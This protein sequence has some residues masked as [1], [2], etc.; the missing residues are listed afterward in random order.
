MR[1]TVISTDRR[2]LT[3]VA[4]TMR[5]AQEEIFGP[6]CRSSKSRAF[7]EAIEVLNGTPYGLSSSIYTQDVEP[8]LSAP[9]GTSKPAS[10]TS[11]ARP[12]APRSTCPSAA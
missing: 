7:E 5:I 3:R 8:G 10:S 9:C 12:S 11:T 6:C 1:P 2:S 4:P